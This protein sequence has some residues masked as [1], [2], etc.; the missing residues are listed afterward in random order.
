MEEGKCNGKK[1]ILFDGV[2]NLCDGFVRFVHKLDSDNQ[3]HFCPLQSK[4]GKEYI[5]AYDLPNDLST[6][7]FVEEPNYSNEG[8]KSFSQSSAA[9]RIISYLAYPW[10]LLYFLI[11]I[12]PIIRDTV[13][14]FVSSSRY[15]VFGKGKQD[16]CSHVPGLRKKF[17]DL[18]EDDDD[19][20]SHQVHQPQQIPPSYPHVYSFPPHQYDTSSKIA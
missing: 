2:C 18:G 4:T 17:L 9:L 10:C 7:C 6:V 5:S 1:V 3:I 13:Y 12:P 20:I 15:L 19:R 11:L 16:S 8:G 14:N